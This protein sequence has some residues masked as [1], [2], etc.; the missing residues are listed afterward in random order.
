MLS[1]EKIGVMPARPVFRPLLPTFLILAGFCAICAHVLI[2]ARVATRERAADTAMSLIAAIKS[3]VSRNIETLDLSL[4]G[5]VDNLRYPGIHQI[6]PQLRQLVL[7]DRSATARHLGTILVIDE[8]GNVRLDSRTIH[9]AA[10]NFADRD[11]FQ[12]HE[13][14]ETLGTY[15]GRPARARVSGEWFIGVSRRLSH[16]DGSFA[17]VV[18]AT[19]HLSYFRELF[20]DLALGPDSTVTLSHADGTLLMRWP[21]QEELLGYNLKNAALHE[22]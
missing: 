8:N 4:Q 21:Y 17:G 15:I 18:V 2:Q 11:Y 3:D 16:A 13:Q 9:P 14:D 1:A 22:H 20:K 5:V 19:L 7:F 10:L 6:D 12:A